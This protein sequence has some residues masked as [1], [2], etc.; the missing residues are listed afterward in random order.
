MRGEVKIVN[1]VGDE[2]ANGWELWGLNLSI[3]EL[4]LRY[5]GGSLL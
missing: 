2:V 5:I 1:L 4:G 3:F